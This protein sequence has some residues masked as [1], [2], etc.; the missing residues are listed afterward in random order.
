MGTPLARKIDNPALETTPISG[1]PS[2]HGPLEFIQHTELDIYALSQT[3]DTKFRILNPLEAEKLASVAFSRVCP[4]DGI[5]EAAPV[6]GKSLLQL[7]R[8]KACGPSGDKG[9]IPRP[10]L[11]L[12]PF[13]DLDSIR[14][15]KDQP[16]PIH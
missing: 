14:P 3:V 2:E 13:I 6:A 10:D 1:I 7:V 12:T 8:N 16:T 15:F 11:S 5:Q 4:L 9:F